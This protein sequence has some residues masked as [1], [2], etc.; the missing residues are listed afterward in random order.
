M[1][2]VYVSSLP[3]LG[4]WHPICEAYNRFMGLGRYSKTLFCLLALHTKARIHYIEIHY[5]V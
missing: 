1:H 2:F 4:H 3:K 5:R